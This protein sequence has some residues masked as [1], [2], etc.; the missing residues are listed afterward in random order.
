MDWEDIRNKERS[1][2]IYAVAKCDWNTLFY[3]KRLYQKDLT[4]ALEIIYKQK[5]LI[6]NSSENSN[7]L[8]KI[9]DEALQSADRV[10]SINIAKEE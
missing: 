6:S 1:N 5:E 10:L 3:M 4:K 8:A 9:A 2:S 7:K